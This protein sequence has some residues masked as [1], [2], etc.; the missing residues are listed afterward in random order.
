MDN[1][2]RLVIIL[3]IILGAIIIVGAISFVIWIYVT[4]GNVPL[5][6]LPAWI[7]PYFQ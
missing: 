5:K 6:D 2:E 4:Y 3:A 1:R 7:L